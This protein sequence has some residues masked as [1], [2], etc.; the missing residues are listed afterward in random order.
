M[1]PLPVGRSVDYASEIQDQPAAYNE[2]IQE[3]LARGQKRKKRR[4]RYE[5]PP[6]PPQLPLGMLGQG[7]ATAA[8][9]LAIARK[10][11]GDRE[12]WRS[13]LSMLAK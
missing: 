13:E 5:L 4:R 11:K 12:C 2:L 7:S 9:L 1:A 8:M 6:A 3:Q 10:C